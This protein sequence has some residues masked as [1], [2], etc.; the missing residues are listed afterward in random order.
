VAVVCD[1]EPD[2]L[3]SRLAESFGSL[4]PGSER[5]DSGRASA[6][7]LAVRPW[8]EALPLSATPGS[9]VL[10]GEFAAPPPDSP[11]YPALAV[12]LAMLDDLLAR[13]MRDS[14]SLAYGA[15]TTLATSAAS[16]ASLMVYRT[17]SPGKAKEAVDAA[18]AELASG[19]CLDPSSGESGPLARSLEAYQ[20]RAIAAS[21]SGLGSSRGMAASIAKDLASGG[22]GSSVFGMAARIRAVRGED[23]E[24]VARER[25]LEGPSAWVA[26]GDPS[27]VL[28]LPK[29]LFVKRGAAGRL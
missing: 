5:K 6:G 28:G 27:L 18:I 20:A 10:R 22:D 25:L 4:K 19:S 24:R 26:L 15:W 17:A 1:E 2:L 7:S 14:A 29:D 8:F 21:Y 3:S 12:A 13:R 11:D 23:V 16:S 9:A